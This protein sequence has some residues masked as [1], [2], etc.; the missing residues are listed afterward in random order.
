MHLISNS[1][2]WYLIH[3]MGHCPK[4]VLEQHV[5]F[6]G[7][8]ASNEPWSSLVVLTSDLDDNPQ[9]IHP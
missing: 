1:L 9:I 8:R 4:N 7:C 6:G 5:G 2:E 3:Y